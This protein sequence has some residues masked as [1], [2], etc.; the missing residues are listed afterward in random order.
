M[1]LTEF[2][3]LTDSACLRLRDM[4][5]GNEASNENVDSDIETAIM[6]VGG[7]FSIRYIVG[8]Q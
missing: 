3:T 2:P 8:T 4:V 7:I 5:S 6:A 1:V